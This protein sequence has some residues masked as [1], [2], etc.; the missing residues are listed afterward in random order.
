MNNPVLDIQDYA[1]KQRIVNVK[2]FLAFEFC[3]FCVVIRFFIP[4]TMAN[5]FDFE[6]FSIPD[7]ILY[8]YLILIL[9]KEQVLPCFNVEC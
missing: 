5:D 2:L 8:I 4:V 3:R 6:G 1:Q 7:F 9:E